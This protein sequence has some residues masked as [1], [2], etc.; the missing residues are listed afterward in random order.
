MREPFLGEGTA[1]VRAST[2][3]TSH[4]TQLTTGRFMFVACQLMVRTEAGR[5]GRADHRDLGWGEAFLLEV[6]Y[7]RCQL[8][9]ASSSFHLPENPLSFFL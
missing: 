7:I 1:P 5:V 3:K 4:C 8:A 9:R 6:K 2:S